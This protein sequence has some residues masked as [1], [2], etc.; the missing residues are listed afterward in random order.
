MERNEKDAEKLQDAASAKKKKWQPPV[1]QRLDTR[2]S[3]ATFTSPGG[4]DFG[5]YGS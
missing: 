5:G 2:E 1:L 4:T 3:A